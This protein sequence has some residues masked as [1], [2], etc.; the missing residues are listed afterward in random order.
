[1]QASPRSLTSSIQERE[2]RWIRDHHVCIT[3]ILW[4]MRVPK[5]PKTHMYTGNR[6]QGPPVSHSEKAQAEAGHVGV[7]R[8][9]DRV[10]RPLVG[11]SRASTWCTPI[12]PRGH[13]RGVSLHLTLVPAPINRRGRG[14][15]IRQHTWRQLLTLASFTP[16]H[17]FLV[18]VKPHPTRDMSVTRI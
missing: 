18:E 16:S 1:M 13:P 2:P 14:V 4:P 10:N 11:W 8:P 17:S 6:P 5:P 12:G 7:S 3:W 9:W 15:R